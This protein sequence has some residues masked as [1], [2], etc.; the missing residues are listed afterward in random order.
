LII[1]FFDWMFRV[2][3]KKKKKKINKKNFQNF[4]FKKRKKK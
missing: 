4:L 1:I 2:F 3:G